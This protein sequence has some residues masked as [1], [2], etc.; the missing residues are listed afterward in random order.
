MRQNLNKD[1][2]KSFIKFFEWFEINR[3]PYQFLEAQGGDQDQLV[4]VKNLYGKETNRSLLFLMSHQ[5]DIDDLNLTTIFGEE[6]SDIDNGIP[7][8]LLLMLCDTHFLFHNLTLDTFIDASLL[9]FEEL[10]ICF[11]QK[12]ILKISLREFLKRSNAKTIYLNH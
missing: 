3:S 12:E 1:H 6:F 5:N 7:H 4:K 9:K 10:Y 11:K 2:T 8:S